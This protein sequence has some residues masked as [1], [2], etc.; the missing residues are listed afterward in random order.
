MSPK[1]PADLP[2]K[3]SQVLKRSI[4]IA[5]HKT[6]VTLEVAFWSAFKEIAATRKIPI[7]RPRVYKRQRAPARQPFVDN[8]PVCSR[9]LSRPGKPTRHDTR[10][11]ARAGALMTT[12]RLGSPACAGRTGLRAARPLGHHDVGH[13]EYA[14]AKARTASEGSRV[15]ARAAELR[16]GRIGRA[17]GYHRRSF[18]G[19]T[20]SSNEG[21]HPAR[22]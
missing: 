12:P 21:H 7:V 9:V 17:R 22:R 4:L 2:R 1:Q 13:P 20:R 10:Q 6:S 16:Q 15:A 19:P 11:H 3:P 8:P 14:A 18:C 5:G